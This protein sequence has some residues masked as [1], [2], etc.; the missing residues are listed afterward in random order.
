MSV[1]S[2]AIHKGGVGKTTIA[3]ALARFA[4][5]QGKTVL[6]IDFDPQS[7]ATGNFATEGKQRSLLASH[8]LSDKPTGKPMNVEKN[9]DLIPAD[10]GLLEA[11]MK[12]TAVVGPL[13]ANVAA[14]SKRYDMV[15]FDTPPSMGIG[16]LAPLMV[17]DYCLSPVVPDAYG[18]SGLEA[19]LQRIKL[20]KRSSNPKLNFL[21]LLV[22][23]YRFND[24]GHVD[25]LRLLR[26]QGSQ[27]LVPWI[28]SEYAALSNSAH[29]KKAAWE[30]AKSP[31][32]KKA[33]KALTDALDWIFSQMFPQKNDQMS[34][35][36]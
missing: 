32:A 28:V 13:K 9:L 34:V 31:S 8:L 6:L 26:K 22:N 11:E 27:F 10:M 17:S 35:S 15:V 36:L 5:K 29:T 12:G 2:I 7:N 14:L 25:V 19:L 3:V 24:A 16:M 30:T 33:S 20:I 1:I 23:R 4:A 18:V 21:G